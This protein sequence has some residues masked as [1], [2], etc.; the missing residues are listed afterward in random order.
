MR[1]FADDMNF[2]MELNPEKVKATLAK[3]V[4]EN[5]M[6]TIAPVTI[7]DNTMY[8]PYNPYNFGETSWEICVCVCFVCV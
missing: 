1:K 3:G 2:K 6:Y 7:N 4:Q 8:S 5:G